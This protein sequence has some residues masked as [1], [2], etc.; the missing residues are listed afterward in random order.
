MAYIFPKV[1]RPDTLRYLVKGEEG[2]VIVY[3]VKWQYSFKDS[4][5]RHRLENILASWSCPG[6]NGGLLGVG[7]RGSIGAGMELGDADQ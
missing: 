6:S 5:A 2:V 4:W 3:M 1:P 7:R